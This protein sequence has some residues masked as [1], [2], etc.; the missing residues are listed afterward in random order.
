MQTHILEQGAQF[1]EWL[2]SGAYIYI[3]GD[4]S[5]MAADVDTAIRKVIA[6]HGGVDEAGADAY[7]DKLVSEH[8]YQR[9]VY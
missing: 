5:R 4:A 1:Y 2:E 3:C 9:D 6:E 7:M 8:R